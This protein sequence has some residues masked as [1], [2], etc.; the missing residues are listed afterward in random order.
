ML[1][2]T[3]STDESGPK[4]GNGNGEIDGF[5]VSGGSEKFAKKS[6][7]LKSQNL[8]KSQKLFK[9][10]KSKDKKSKKLLKSG[11]SLTFEATEA[12]LSFLTPGASKA[13]NRLWLAFTKALILQYFNP[14]CHIWIKTNVLGYTI[15]DVP[16]QLASETRL[17]GVVTK[18]NLIQ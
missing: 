11:N 10:R 1:K 16:S 9:L 7:K 12:K 18:T 4:V 15:G 2:T 8:A 6:G 14:E 5:G 17:D 3:K 13:F